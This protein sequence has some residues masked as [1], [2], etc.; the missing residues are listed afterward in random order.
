MARARQARS[1][2]HVDGRNL[3]FRLLGENAEAILMKPPGKVMISVEGLM[4]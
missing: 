4:G 1:N 2:G 3:V